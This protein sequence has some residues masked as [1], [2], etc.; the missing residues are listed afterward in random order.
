MINPPTFNVA[1]INASMRRVFAWLMSRILPNGTATLQTTSNNLWSTSLVGRVLTY[2]QLEMGNATTR[3]LIQNMTSAEHLLLQNPS[4]VMTGVWP[5]ANFTSQLRVHLDAQKFLSRAYGITLDQTARS[6]MISTTQNLQ[7]NAPNRDGYFDTIAWGLSNAIWF[8][9]YTKFPLP[10]PTDF[11]TA[12]QDLN[13]RF[14]STK[15]RAVASSPYVDFSTI[16]H[17]LRAYAYTDSYFRLRGSPLDQSYLDLETGLANQLVRRQMPNGN[18]T[19]LNQFKS[20]LVEDF[21]RDLDTSTYLEDNLT[22]AFSAFKAES[23]LT[24]L[25]LQQN[26]NFSLPKSGEGT[27]T[28]AAPHMLAI[29]NDVRPCSSDAWSSM[30]LSSSRIINYTLTTQYPDGTFRFFLNRTNPGFA[31]TT[32]GAVSSLVDS[33]VILRNKNVLSPLQSTS[34]S[35]CQPTAPASPFQGLSIL[36]VAIPIAGIIGVAIV[37]ETRHRSKY[38]GLVEK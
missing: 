35:A 19:T 29:A 8:A 24:S 9:Y 20:Y 33:Y 5:A 37:Y 6:D 10:P 13:T 3:A 18:L 1:G 4:Y 30:L 22:Y 15:A 21:A 26:G 27:S 14:N 17:Y 34:L 38:H 32:A 12:V 28:T 36:L 2:L 31:L 23:F 16:L 11:T 7:L 25:Y